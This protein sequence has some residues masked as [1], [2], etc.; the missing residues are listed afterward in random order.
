MLI[1]NKIP[2]TLYDNLIT[3]YDTGKD[4]ELKGYLSK[5]IKNKNYNAQ[6]ACLA[7]KQLMYGFAKEMNFD[8]KAQGNKSTRDKTLIN[9]LESPGLRVTAP[10]V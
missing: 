4:F 10:G 6:L 2:V 7:D 8:L 1:H 5:M 9:L 3:F